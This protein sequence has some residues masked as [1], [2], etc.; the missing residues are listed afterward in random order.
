MDEQVLEAGT[1]FAL[2]YSPLIDKITLPNH[3][4]KAIL[5]GET[6]NIEVLHGTN[7][8]EMGSTGFYLA[9]ALGGEHYF[10]SQRD[11]VR[12]PR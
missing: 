4:L 10:S 9:P 12:R 2:G 6:K 8:D 3:P 11:N 1:V 7:K 5:D